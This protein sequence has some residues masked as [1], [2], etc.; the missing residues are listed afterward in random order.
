M[1]KRLDKDELPQLAGFLSG[2]LPEAFKLH[3]ALLN[4]IDGKIR[5]EFWVDTWP[6]PKAVV[7]TPVMEIEY[8]SNVYNI[9][10]VS[11]SALTN[12]L[13]EDG[14]MT[15]ENPVVFAAV[16]EDYFPTLVE[17][18]SRHDWYFDTSNPY[19][20]DLYYL[21][22]KH[23]DIG[24]LPEGMRVRDLSPENACLVNDSWKFNSGGGSVSYI[25]SCIERYPSI[26]LFD[27][28]NQ[29]VGFE[30]MTHCGLMGSLYVMPEHRRKGYAKYITSAL[31][32]K[33]FDKR[34]TP[35]VIL[36]QCNE[37]SILF[38]EKLGFRKASCGRVAWMK[39]ERK[40]CGSVETSNKCC[41]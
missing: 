21:D 17:V 35:F 19:W 31:A 40:G 26:G 2:H 34:R 9:F 6:D 25:E 29:P 28:K 39:M 10:A 38:H 27:A 15:W 7:A 41:T 1:A 36:E 18:A 13:E 12:L 30:L 4:V 11:Q 32:Q 5:Q 22:K 20:G 16:A 37:S 23:L 8:I 33:C 24:D 3:G 14:V